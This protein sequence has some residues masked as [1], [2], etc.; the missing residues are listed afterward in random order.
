MEEVKELPC[1]ISVC[2]ECDKKTNDNIETRFD[3]HGDPYCRKCPDRII[4]MREK[5]VKEIQAEIGNF[6]LWYY[7]KNYDE[8]TGEVR[9]LYDAIDHYVSEVRWSDDW[10][11][12]K[13][14]RTYKYNVDDNT[15]NYNNTFEKKMND[16]DRYRL[17]VLLKG[18]KLEILGMK[19]RGSSCYSIIKK[20]FGLKGNKQKVYDQLLKLEESL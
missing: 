11:Y 3:E 18:L 4:E 16:I 6:L 1:D 17:K 9:N 10:L 20:E 13:S 8:S 7:H 2:P 15:Y 5:E 14:I 12:I 19:K